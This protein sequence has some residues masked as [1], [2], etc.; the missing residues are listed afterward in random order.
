MTCKQTKRSWYSILQQSAFY[1]QYLLFLLYGTSVPRFC[2]R[3][4][5]LLRGVYTCSCSFHQHLTYQEGNQRMEYA[6]LQ[7]H[8]VSVK[9]SYWSPINGTS[10]LMPP[11][12]STG[13]F[14]SLVWSNIR[15]SWMCF[16]CHW[17]L[18]L[19]IG[20]IDQ[21]EAAQDECHVISWTCWIRL[22]ISN[23]SRPM[24]LA[25]ESSSLVQ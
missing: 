18:L 11:N 9:L 23:G 3:F 4:L 8:S 5:L 19:S 22:L 7:I 2:G 1:K 25:G 12:R 24:S 15:F 14:K 6:E 17:L 13:I 20:L 10:T 21:T 16:R